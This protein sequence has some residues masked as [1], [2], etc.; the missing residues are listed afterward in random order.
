MLPFDVNKQ[1]AQWTGSL[2]ADYGQLYLSASIGF[3]FAALFAGYSPNKTPIPVENAM[4]R[5]TMPVDRV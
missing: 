2:F 4:D 3:F 5:R 1:A